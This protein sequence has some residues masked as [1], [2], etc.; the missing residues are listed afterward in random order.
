L[1]FVALQH[2]KAIRWA[3]FD[4]DARLT[5]RSGQWIAQWLVGHGVPKSKLQ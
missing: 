4:G 5:R 3:E 1:A 2:G